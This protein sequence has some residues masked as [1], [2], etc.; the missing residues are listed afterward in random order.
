MRELFDT[1]GNVYTTPTTRFGGFW[2]RQNSPGHALH[3]KPRQRD[4]TGEHGTQRA[5]I[6][7]MDSI[8]ATHYIT[9]VGRKD[10]F[11][12]FL[13]R[14]RRESTSPHDSPYFAYFQV[15]FVNRNAW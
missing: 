8:C 2:T 12:F 4:I 14:E 10:C 15:G 7:M 3:A 1:D 13:S 11:S 6:W 5:G 9:G